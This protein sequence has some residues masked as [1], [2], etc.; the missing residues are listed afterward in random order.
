MIFWR[1]ELLWGKKIHD[2][3]GGCP[4]SRSA[5][6]QQNKPLYLLVPMLSPSTAAGF[7]FFTCTSPKQLTKSISLFYGF[8][9]LR[10]IVP[11]SPTISCYMSAR[12]VCLFPLMQFWVQM[13]VSHVCLYLWQPTLSPAVSPRQ[14]STHINMPPGVSSLKTVHTPSFNHRQEPILYQ[15]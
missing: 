1:L 13:Y 2:C 4:A 8:H 14:E 6:C 7:T 11:K 9:F 10:E 3:S 12:F 15:A 5:C